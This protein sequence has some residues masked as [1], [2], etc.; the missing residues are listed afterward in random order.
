MPEL[1]IISRSPILPPCFMIEDTEDELAAV[2]RFH[3]RATSASNQFHIPVPAP[4][5]GEKERF[6][7]REAERER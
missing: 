4:D 6:I 1:E 2:R 5:L 7:F 3:C